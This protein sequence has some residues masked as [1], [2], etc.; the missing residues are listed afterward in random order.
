MTTDDLTEC[1]WPDLSPRYATALRAAVRFVFERFEPQAVIAAGS[2]IRGVGDRRSDLDIYVVQGSSYKQRLQR[3][4]GD[5]PAEIFVNPLPAIR[6]YFASEHQQG[7][8]A[9]AHMIAS[10][11]PVFGGQALDALRAEA[12]EWLQKRRT[13]SQDEDTWARYS[14]ATLLEDSEDVAERDPALA[15]AL[16]GEAVLAM[17]RY[18]L[19]VQNGVVPGNKSLLF[20]LE[21]GDPAVAELARRFFTASGI[22]ERLATARALADCTIRARGFF[23]WDS[24]RIAVSPE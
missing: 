15:S 11:F 6:E 3:W 10:G 12:S 24:E 13:M 1:H 14:A 17:L 22:E 19:R 9:T 18:H 21:R 8:P 20:E 2:I 4:F 7:R 5:V 23:E 16:L